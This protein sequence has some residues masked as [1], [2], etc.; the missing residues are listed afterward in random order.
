MLHEL[1]SKIFWM[2]I[3]VISAMA[4]IVL[5]AIWMYRENVAL[6]F[7]WTMILGFIIE[8]WMLFVVTAWVV[9]RWLI[10]H[11]TSF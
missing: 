4:G 2:E 9:A 7:F 6:V 5:I 11:P 3:D 1:L 8:F 10:N